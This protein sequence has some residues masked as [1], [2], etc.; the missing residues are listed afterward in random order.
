MT[1][2]DGDSDGP[3]DTV[4]ADDDE[5]LVLVAG[6]VGAAALATVSTTFDP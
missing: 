1:L 3:G 4:G 2:T 6:V 5:E